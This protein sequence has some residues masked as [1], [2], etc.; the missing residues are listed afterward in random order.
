MP[1][2]CIFADKGPAAFVDDNSPEALLA[3]CALLNT[4]AFGLL[5]SVQLARTELAQSFEVGLIHLFPNSTLNN[6]PSLPPLRGAPGRSN[7]SSTPSMKPR[8]PI[9]CPPPCA[10]VLATTIRPPSTRS[11]RVSRPRSTPSPLTF[12]ASARPT[13]PPRRPPLPSLW[14]RRQRTMRRQTM[15][16]RTRTVR[17]PS[18]RRRAYSAGPSAWPS[19]ASTGGSPQASAPP[20]PSRSR[21][22]RCPRKAPACCPM[23]PSRSTATPAFWSTIPATRTTSPTWWKKC[24]PASTPPCRPTCAAGC[25]ATSSRSTCSVTARAAARRRSIGRSR[26]RRAATRCGS[27]TPA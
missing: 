6:R 21:S 23:G 16:P 18:T 13:D 25:N 3:V 7:A 8:T 15:T 22:T 20:R 26:R 17:P 27:I 10:A 1:R 12:T 4:Q 19:A 11:W 14:K 2:D 5:V 9:C 24:S